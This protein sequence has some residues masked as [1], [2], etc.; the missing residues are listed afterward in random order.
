MADPKTRT[1]VRA[2]MQVRAADDRLL[3]TVT[4][5]GTRGSETAV[6]VTPGRSLLVWLHLSHRAGC[7]YLPGSAVDVVAGQ[8]VR[9]NI[10]ARAARGY[11]LRPH[12]FIG[13]TTAN[14]HAG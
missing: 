3:G 2:S 8:Q 7:L 11:T 14:L 4:G 13:P 1:Q 5:V 10:D 12:W 6:E 9:L